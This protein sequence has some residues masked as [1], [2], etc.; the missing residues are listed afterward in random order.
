MNSRLSNFNSLPPKKEYTDK[1]LKLLTNKSYT[2]LE[3]IKKTNLT[4][5][6]V[7]CSIDELL[8]RNI[9]DIKYN[10]L[11]KKV[12]FIKENNE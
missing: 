6:Q 7:G 2:F 12:Y 5:T 10:S 3:I 9:L 4:R 1:I 8:S 11:D